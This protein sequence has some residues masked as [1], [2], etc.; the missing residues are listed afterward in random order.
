M[1]KR[2]LL[3]G[4]NVSLLTHDETLTVCT[5]FS[6]GQFTAPGINLSMRPLSYNR[7]QVRPVPVLR[8]A[9]KPAVPLV[10]W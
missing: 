6:E 8:L 3:N 7:M 2:S 1:E 4:C 9:L 10:T 5:L